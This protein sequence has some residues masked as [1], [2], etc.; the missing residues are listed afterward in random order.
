VQSIEVVKTIRNTARAYEQTLDPGRRKQLGQFFSGVPLGK[1]L[2]HLSFNPVTRTVLDPMAGHGDLLDATWEV[3]VERGITLER[4]DGIEIDDSTAV[5]CRN[6]LALTP[7][8]DKRPE[9]VIVTGNAFEPATLKSLPMSSYDLVITNPPYVRYQG[10]KGSGDSLDNARSGLKKVVQSISDESSRIVWSTLVQGYSGL[11]DLSIPAWI[12]A[13]F[14]VRPGGRLALIVPAT[15]RSRDYADVIRYLL[16]RY[17]VVETIVADTQPG[18]FSDALVRTNLI[19]AQRLMGEETRRPL[20]EKSHWTA[21]RWLHI[22]PS[23]ANDHSLVGNAFASDHPEAALSEWLKKPS[24]TSIESIEV[25]NFDLCHEW[26]TLQSRI[27]RYRWYPMVESCSKDLSLFPA[28][29]KSVAP[30]LPDA[31]R[32]VLP[33]DAKPANLVTL[34]ESGIKVGQGLRTGCNGFFYVTV[35][36]EGEGDMMPIRSSSAVGNWTFA[37]SSAALRPVL[38]RQS[39]IVLIEK[40]SFPPGRVLNLRAWVLPEDVQQVADAKAAYALRHETPPQVM[41]ADLA[42]FV[43]HAASVSIVGRGSSIPIPELSAV[44]TNVR[45]ARTNTLTPRFWYMLPDFRQRHLPA[46]FVPRVNQGTPW[47][48]CNTRPPLLIDANFSTFWAIDDVWSPF[49]IKAMLNSVWCRAY[50]EA[51]GTPLGGGALKLEA[52]HL[53]QMPIPLLTNCDRVALH[54]AGKYMRRNTQEI[55]AQ[56]D[57]IV[58]QAL[59][60]DNPSGTTLS[61]FATYLTVQMSK[62][63]AARQRTAS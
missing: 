43:R 44:R 27:T 58:L 37:V 30:V 51:A 53:R 20:S 3:A 28:W 11:A 38:R 57:R 9:S 12:L 24:R 19:V 29:S 14:M 4:I 48:E 49:A 26:A 7:T 10:R 1:L 25:R 56:I 23:A 5:I 18:W 41:P 13:G 2:A 61:N 17:F 15:W 62:L 21:A 40:G 34:E 42:A 45:R 6:R 59:Y 54:T 47:I 55:Q 8:N 46:A 39:E 32:Q 33:T 22:S 52:T 63:C 60:S 31:L 16:L 36:G 35:C 50:M